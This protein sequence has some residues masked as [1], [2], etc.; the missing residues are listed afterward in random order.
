MPDPKSR[1]AVLIDADNTSA[2]YVKE[3]MDEVAQFGTPTVRRAYGDW[4]SP[5]LQGWRDVLVPHAIQPMHQFAYTT[6][7]NSTDAALIIDAMDL[8]YSGTLDAFAIVSSDSDFTRLVVRLRE[9][10]MTVYG[11]GQRKTPESLVGVCDRFIYLEV[12]KASKDETAAAGDP[13][14]PGLRPMLLRAIDAA[15]HDD[16]WATLAEVG[17]LLTK[18]HAAFDPRN[19]G[20]PKLSTLARA[21]DYLEVDVETPGTARVRRAVRT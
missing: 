10:A 20:Y 5:H 14:D 16:G 7:K 13:L 3:L 11:F 12:L 15:S 9:S 6:G 1:I 18:S 21:Q 19:Y 2:K 17:N 4:T 8:L